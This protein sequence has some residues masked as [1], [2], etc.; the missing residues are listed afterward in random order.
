MCMIELMT[1][2]EIMEYFNMKNGFLIDLRMYAY[3][4]LKNLWMGKGNFGVIIR[5]LNA[6]IIGFF[7][8]SCWS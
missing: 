7:H 5:E 4:F 8:G 1:S 6:T 3:W 2:G